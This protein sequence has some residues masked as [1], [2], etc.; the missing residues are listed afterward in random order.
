MTRFAAFRS[1]LTSIMEALS[2]AAVAEICELLDDSCAVLQ[3]EIRR[4]HAENQALRR[5]LELMQDLVARGHRDGGPGED[6]SASSG[7]P[8]P[9]SNLRRNGRVRV[10][11]AP[12]A[13][14]DDSPAGGAEA[15]GDQDGMEERSIKTEDD[16]KLLT[17]EEGAEPHFL[18]GDDP[19]G[20]ASRMR[21]SP[22]VDTAPWEP[23]ALQHRSTGAPGSPTRALLGVLGRG[24][25][26]ERRGASVTGA[27]RSDPDVEPSSAWTAPAPP[28]AP[29]SRLPAL[30]PGGSWAGPL[31]QNQ[32][33]RDRRFVCSCCRK[34]FTSSRSL[35]THMRVHTGERPYSCPQCGKRFTQSGH[36]KT[37]QSV[38][39][40]ERPFA[41]QHCGKRFAG[42]QNLRIHQQKHHPAERGG[43]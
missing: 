34:G 32:H 30:G 12:P 23:S 27:Q 20:G 16:D 3:L 42:R 11:T 35:E 29:G 33:C 14:E 37:H 10:S 24:P 26:Q 7:A 1:Q 25:S 2:R 22:G 28:G 38:H 18:V 39:T 6:C 31:D 40:G 15:A 43:A 5:K 19:K 21:T 13:G 41:C 17:R 4:S 8:Q 36:L 9:K